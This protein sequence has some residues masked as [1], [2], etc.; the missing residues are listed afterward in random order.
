[1]RT[2]DGQQTSQKSPKCSRLG[3]VASIEELDERH[4]Y[5]AHGAKTFWVG[6]LPL[7][8]LRTP[9]VLECP[10]RFGNRGLL[11]R[12]LCRKVLELGARVGR[13]GFLEMT[14]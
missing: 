9:E 8:E 14:G 12:A 13:S 11:G 10:A 6:V 4:R 2:S 7:I 5:R 1:M 3:G